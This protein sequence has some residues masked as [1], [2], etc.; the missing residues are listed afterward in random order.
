VGKKQLA[1]LAVVPALAMSVLGTAVASPPAQIK[2]GVAGLSEAPVSVVDTTGTVNVVWTAVAPSTGYTL[3]R[4]AREPKG[5]KRF[6]QVALPKVADDA[7]P[8][9][10]E[11]A[12]G[13]LQII[14]TQNSGEFAQIGFRSTNDGKSWKTMNTAALN[15][16]SLRASGVYL[17][18]AY[19][20]ETSGGPAEYAGDDGDPAGQVVQFNE[21]LTKVTTIATNPQSLNFPHVGRTAS[22]V[23][24]LMDTPFNTETTDVFTVGS[25]SGQVVF[26]ACASTEN[27]PVLAVGHSNAV[28][29][30]SGCGR[31]YARSISTSGKVGKL[32]RLGS[33]PARAAG[34][35]GTATVSVVA[36]R[37]GHFTAAYDVPGGDLQVAH[38]TN[39]ARWTTSAP[40]SVPISNGFDYG[41]N[42]AVSG[43][44]ATW[45][46]T[47]TMNL[48]A[49]NYTVAA[50]PLSATYRPPSAPSAHGIAHPRRGHLGSLAVVVPGKV[51]MKLIRKSGRIKITLV[52]ALKTT[53]P[54]SVYVTQSSANTV[55]Y[56][57][58]ADSNVALKAGHARTV[59]E[60]CSGGGTTVGALRPLHA[61]AK[62]KTVATF[63]FGGRNGTLTLTSP[64]T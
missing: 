40:R 37:S 43:G 8:F 39:G 63:T 3:V 15:D 4:Y 46:A 13:V 11:A 2:I 54:V 58:Q 10:Y 59:T 12:P 21:N 7:N 16:P 25:H 45:Y 30:Y 31:V 33:S 35:A 44:A 22:G 5:A 42:G 64:V 17:N 36:D 50:I 32:I 34:V 61:A 57:C 14:V 48:T 55:L 6:T 26:P 18:S 29:V 56:I 52:D 19:L 60:V 62:K 41:V 1:V 51:S 23:T 27:R 28:A 9:I 20:V 53:I 24:F 38:S 49:N 47:A